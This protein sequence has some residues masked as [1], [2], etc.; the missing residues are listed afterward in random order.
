MRVY[1]RKLS[2]G[3]AYCTDADDR[4]RIVLAND[5]VSVRFLYFDRAGAEICQVSTSDLSGFDL[6]ID[7]FCHL[8]SAL[9]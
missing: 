2:P 6:T 9:G 5:G 7:G 3:T 4:V 8:G 1:L